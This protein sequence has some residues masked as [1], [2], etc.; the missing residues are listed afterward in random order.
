MG[1]IDGI[2]Y[3]PERKELNNVSLI[4]MKI[5]NDG[6]IA[7]ADSKASRIDKNNM[8]YEDKE[9]G[10]IRKIFKNNHFIVATSGNN[11]IIKTKEILPIEVVIKNILYKSNSIGDFLNYFI[12][13][14][15]DDNRLFSF[16]FGYKENN[17]YLIRV[18]E[19]E[20]K[21]IDLKKVISNKD[22]MYIQGEKKCVDF[23][24]QMNFKKYE[25]ISKAKENIKPILNSLI[26]LYDHFNGYNSVG[27]PINIEILT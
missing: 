19:I 15:E 9:R 5:C 23:L 25:T 21:K 11:E 27:K 18:Y 16:V 2:S 3:T 8:I 17:Q 14:L 13:M 20:N 4:T 1:I 10:Y 12:D 6:I 24:K 7:F 26:V 22:I